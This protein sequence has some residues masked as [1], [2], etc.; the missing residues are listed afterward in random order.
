M[1]LEKVS[2]KLPSSTMRT[3]KLRVLCKEFLASNESTVKCLLDTDEYVSLS[4]AQSSINGMI[5]RNA[6]PIKAVASNCELYLVRTD[7]VPEEDYSLTTENIK[8]K[9][10]AACERVLA[11]FMKQHDIHTGDITP[12]QLFVLSRHLDEMANI[13]LEIIDQNKE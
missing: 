4:S 8:E 1:K 5:K 9:M 7:L 3:T 13:Y 2:S 12:H 11:D 10:E 6:F